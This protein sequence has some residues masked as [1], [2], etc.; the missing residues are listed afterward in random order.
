M[1][2]FNIFDSNSFNLENKVDKVKNA[3]K[4]NKYIPYKFKPRTKRYNN[5]S[6]TKYVDEKKKKL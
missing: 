4:L 5:V 1:K 3:I 6:K 2:I